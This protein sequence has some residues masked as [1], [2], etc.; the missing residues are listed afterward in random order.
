RHGPRRPLDRVGAERAGNRPGEDVALVVHVLR[1]VRERGLGHAEVLTE[2]VARRVL[3]PIGYE[4]GL[5]LREVAV[6]EDEQELTA[7]LEPLD[8]V[9][10]AARE[11]PEAPPAALV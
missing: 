1:D 5:V 9:R 4:E 2:D 10:G 3:E 8:G 11:G 7:L 6:V